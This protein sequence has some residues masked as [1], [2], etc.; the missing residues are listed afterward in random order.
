MQANQGRVPASVTNLVE[1]LRLPGFPIEKS[2]LFYVSSN[3]NSLHHRLSAQV[4]A[5]LLLAHPPGHHLLTIGPF[6]R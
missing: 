4:S 6:S 2:L 5:I 1:F 3:S